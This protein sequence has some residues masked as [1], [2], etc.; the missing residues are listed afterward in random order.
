MKIVEPS[1]SL[2]P[3]DFSPLQRIEI[4]GRVCYQSSPCPGR[5]TAEAF[6]RRLIARGH[7]SVLEHF[8]MELCQPGDIYELLRRLRRMGGS[9]ARAIRGRLTLVENND[10]SRAILNA[11]DYLAVF[12]DVD[13]RELDKQR[14]ARDYATLSIVCD[15]AIANELVRHRVFSF[16][17]ESTRY[18][19]YKDGI[20]VVSPYPT[21]DP[22][23]LSI[24]RAQMFSAEGAY[25]AMLEK[26]AT[27]QEARNVL[28]LSTKTQLVM[29]GTYPQ[30]GDLLALRDAPDAHPQMRHVA[31]L[32][33]AT[34]PVAMEGRAEQ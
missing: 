13:V 15:R 26:G 34:L 9:T 24:W 11:R 32:I 18:V 29:T 28:P 23:R 7:T 17:Q 3:A 21:F 5:D 12:P 25:F 4:C 1:V 30:W 31:K 2:I 8:R 6:A 33:R 20:T 22:E 14:H 16:S 27:P 10:D 19:N